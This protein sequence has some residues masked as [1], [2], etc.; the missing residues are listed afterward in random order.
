MEG[1]INMKANLVLDSVAKIT[2]EFI[3][4]G[5]SSD[6]TFSEYDTETNVLGFTCINKNRKYFVMNETGNIFNDRGDIYYYNIHPRKS[7]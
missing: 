4:K 5:W 2:A 7:E 1:K 3:R 6:I